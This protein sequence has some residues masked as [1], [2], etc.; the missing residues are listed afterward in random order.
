MVHV[1][2]MKMTAHVLEIDAQFLYIPGCMIISFGDQSTHTSDMQIVRVAQ[3]LD[4]GKLQDCHKVYKDVVHDVIGVEEAM[5]TLDEIIN[6]KTK[7]N[8]WFIVLAYGFASATVGPFGFKARF[9]DIPPLFFLGCVL[10]ILQVFVEPRSKLYSNVFEISAA[11]I[12]SF[13]SRALGSIRG[14][15]LF[16]FSAMAQ[17]SIALILPGYIICE[18]QISYSYASQFKNLMIIVCGSLELQSR[19][20]NS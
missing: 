17:S 20:G 7:H 12:T 9:I 3:G 4:M 13:L 6:R 14:G 5:Q 1:D 11:I 19:K 10:G 2:A 8:P 15:D 16:C 18:S